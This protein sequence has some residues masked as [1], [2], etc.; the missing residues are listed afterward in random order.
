M[1]VGRERARGPALMLLSVDD[2]V[3]PDTLQRIREVGGLEY[4]KVVRI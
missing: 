3:P 1:Q 4:V 2:P